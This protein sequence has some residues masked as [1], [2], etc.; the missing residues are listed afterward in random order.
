MFFTEYHQVALIQYCSA[1]TALQLLLHCFF[2]DGI[3]FILKIV[4]D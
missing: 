4:T 3:G 2:H 1:T